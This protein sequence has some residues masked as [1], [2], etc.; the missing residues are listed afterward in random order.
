MLKTKLRIIADKVSTILPIDNREEV[1]D[2][3]FTK[4]I[5]FWQFLIFLLVIFGIEVYAS[6]EFFKFYDE[7]RI[8]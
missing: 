6:V 5:F 8:L 4:C 2:I 3:F 1:R 7:V